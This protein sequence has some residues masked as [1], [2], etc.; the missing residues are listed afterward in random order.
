MGTNQ[1]YLTKKK[2]NLNVTVSTIPAV[3]AVQPRD[4]LSDG[5]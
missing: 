1:T 3:S 5:K 2:N 4:K